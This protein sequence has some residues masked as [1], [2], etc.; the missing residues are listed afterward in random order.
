VIKFKNFALEV[1]MGY[2]T[3]T[4]EGQQE[5][6][7]RKLLYMGFYLLIWGKTSDVPFMPRCPWYI[8]LVFDLLLSNPKSQGE[9][10]RHCCFNCA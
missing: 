7:Q 8:L 2:F 5:T 9:Y 10:E 3:R 6:Q 1:L 4:S